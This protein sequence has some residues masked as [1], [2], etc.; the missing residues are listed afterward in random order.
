M[1]RN[2]ES[3]ARFF[4]HD[5]DHLMNVQAARGRLHDQ[6]CGRKPQIVNSSPVLPAIAGKSPAHDAQDEDWRRLGP[7]LIRL[8]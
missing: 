5:S 2:L 4:G 1:L 7:F 3:L 8:D 6:I